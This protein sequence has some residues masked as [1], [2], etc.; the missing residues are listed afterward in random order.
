MKE[1]AKDRARLFIM[2]RT[3]L[4]INKDDPFDVLWDRYEKLKF[5]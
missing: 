5:K 1:Y 4:T 3:N 2:L